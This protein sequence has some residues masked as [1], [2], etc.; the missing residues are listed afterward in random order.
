MKFL[1]TI[2]LILALALVLPLAADAQQV[3]DYSNTID[4][5][6]SFPRLQWFFDNSYGYAVFP[7]VGKAALIVGGAYGPGQV[8]RRGQVT[9]TTDLFQASIGFQWGGQAFSEII[10]F[11]DQWAYEAFT[12]GQYEFDANASAVVVTAG[13]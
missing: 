9:G 2:G 7:V 5:F 11:R 8:Y 3:K 12:R 4:T 10:F 1:R 6:K 13:A